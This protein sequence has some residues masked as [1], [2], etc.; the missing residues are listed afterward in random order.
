[1]EFPEA[2]CYTLF[3][4]QFPEILL[5]WTAPGNS[6]TLIRDCGIVMWIFPRI[7]YRIVFYHKRTGP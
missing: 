7:L 5:E 2:F 3:E 1:M 6:K 4:L